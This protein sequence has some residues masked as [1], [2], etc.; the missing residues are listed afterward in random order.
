L[1]IRAEGKEE[2]KKDE[3]ERKIVLPTLLENVLLHPTPGSLVASSRVKIRT[4]GSVSV[5]AENYS[6]KKV[7]VSIYPLVYSLP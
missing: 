1:P 6:A 5:V 7:L 2:K 4:S 3:E